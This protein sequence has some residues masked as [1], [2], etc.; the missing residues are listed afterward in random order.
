MIKWIL[1]QCIF[2]EGQMYTIEAPEQFT[3]F[4]NSDVKPFL[5]FS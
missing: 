2:D 5:E 3:I 4:L 1:Q